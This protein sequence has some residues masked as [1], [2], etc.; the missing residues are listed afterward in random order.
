MNLAMPPDR[1]LLEADL[2]KP[3]FRAG[4]LDGRW[5]VVRVDWPHVVVS[6]GPAAAVRSRRVRLPVRVHRLS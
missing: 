2:G 4:V 1:L 5:S 3:A 6:V